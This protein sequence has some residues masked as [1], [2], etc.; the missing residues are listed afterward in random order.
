M[1]V[2]LDEETDQ[3][4]FPTV[5]EEVRRMFVKTIN[6]D[7]CYKIKSLLESQVTEEDFDDLAEEMI[8][9]VNDGACLKPLKIS[10]EKDEQPSDC[11]VRRVIEESMTEIVQYHIQKVWGTPQA[12]TDRVLQDL[13]IKSYAGIDPNSGIITYEIVVTVSG[14]FY[15]DIMSYTV[16]VAPSRP[17]SMAETEESLAD[18]EQQVSE[19]SVE[20]PLLDNPQAGHTEEDDTNQEADTSPHTLDSHPA[21]SP[22]ASISTADQAP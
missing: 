10:F 14:L 16:P 2:S 1:E 15:D 5:Y 19:L 18:L 4:P 11:I 8:Q 3:V 9:N 6:A 13:E 17:R 21:V 20:Q 22:D 7:G 12:V